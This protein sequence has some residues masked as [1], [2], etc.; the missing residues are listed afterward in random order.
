MGRKELVMATVLRK[1][2]LD[3]VFDVSEPR[4]TRSEWKALEESERLAEL[5]RAAK[6]RY[7]ANGRMAHGL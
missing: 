5:Q 1:E 3:R 6:S 7:E 2:T 4:L